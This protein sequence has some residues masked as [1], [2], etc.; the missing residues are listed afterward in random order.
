[1]DMWSALGSDRWFSP[2]PINVLVTIFFLGGI[3]EVT[4]DRDK[5]AYNATLLKL[6]GLFKNF[7]TFTNYNIGKD[8]K[9]IKEILVVGPI[10]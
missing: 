3:E 5:N 7:E 2:I 8:D 6:A 1:M 10:F 9:L 4:T